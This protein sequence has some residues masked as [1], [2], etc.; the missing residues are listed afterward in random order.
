MKLKAGLLLNVLLCILPLAF[1]N[2]ALH[3]SSSPFVASTV[4]CFLFV[5]KKFHVFHGLLGNRKTFLSNFC[6]IVFKHCVI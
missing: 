6:D 5:V 3:L 4:Y 1:I 2:E